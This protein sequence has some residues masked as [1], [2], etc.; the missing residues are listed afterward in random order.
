MVR[1]V[2]PQLLGTHV[3]PAP[4][5]HLNQGRFLDAT[6]LQGLLNQE[7]LKGKDLLTPTPSPRLRW[8]SVTLPDFLILPVFPPQDLQG[9]HSLWMSAGASWL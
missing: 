9:T 1:Q 5:P 7:F 2:S 3:T 8:P 6:Q 4:L